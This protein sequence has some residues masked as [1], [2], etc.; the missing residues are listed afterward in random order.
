MQRCRVGP[1]RYEADLILPM[2][3]RW[4]IYIQSE[5]DGVALDDIVLDFRSGAS[6]RDQQREGTCRTGGR[7]GCPSGR[8]RRRFGSVSSCWRS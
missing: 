8:W 2:S 4:V 6:L 5:L 3:G 1:G 7:L